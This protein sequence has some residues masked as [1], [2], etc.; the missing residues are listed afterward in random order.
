M[1]FDPTLSFWMHPIRWIRQRL[2]LRRHNK[3]FEIWWRDT[4]GHRP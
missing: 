4:R 2:E 1:A 3:S